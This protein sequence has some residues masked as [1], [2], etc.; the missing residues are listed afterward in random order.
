MFKAVLGVIGG[1]FA[2]VVVLI[3]GA[4]AFVLSMKRWE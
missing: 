3:G 1:L 4:V 2:I